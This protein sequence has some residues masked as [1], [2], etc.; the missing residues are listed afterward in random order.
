MDPLT[1][2]G[3]GGRA[4]W[5]P[6]EWHP[7]EPIKRAALPASSM[8]RSYLFFLLLESK[9]IESEWILVLARLVKHGLKLAFE[10]NVSISK[11]NKRERRSTWLVIELH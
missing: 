10:T 4:K 5:D 2:S 1:C 9:L 3:G 8:I 11:K 6:S 7:R